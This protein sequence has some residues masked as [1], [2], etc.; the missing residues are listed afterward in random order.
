MHRKKIIRTVL[1]FVIVLSS[2]SLPSR[3]DVSAWEVGEK[4][5]FAIKW[6]FITCGEATMEVNDLFELGGRQTYRVVSRA[7]SA[8]FFDPFY[9]I[10]DE[11]QTFID[12]ENLHS[13]RYEKKQRE[14]SYKADI[15]IIY[16]HKREVAYE[17]GEKFEIVEGIQDE[18]SSLYYLRTK[19]LAVG[20]EFE[21]SVG[22]SKK[23]WP[24][25]VEV[26]KKETVKVPA[27]K[28]ETFLVVPHIIEEGGIFKAEGK[29]RIWITA[30]EQK[31]PVLM[32]AK[33]PFGHITAV[34]KKS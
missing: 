25:K 27:G 29:L 23:T 24:L 4:L 17:D 2:V 31:K 19:E 7:R 6:N 14:G 15:T 33:V 28:F 34:L 32:K 21:F 3:A 1:V 13:V 26:V 9:K 20:K 16:D 8:R 30:D 11:I 10:R 12:K 18:L 22:T 5:T